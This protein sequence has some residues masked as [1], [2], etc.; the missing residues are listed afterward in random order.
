FHDTVLTRANV[1][2]ELA[3]QLAFVHHASYPQVPEAG[4]ELLRADDTTRLGIHVE[5][6]EFLWV[7]LLVQA[8]EGVGAEKLGE[9]LDAPNSRVSRVILKYLLDAVGKRGVEDLHAFPKLLVGLREL[10]DARMRQ[11]ERIAAG[12][13]G[14][15][16]EV[17]VPVPVQIGAVVLLE[18]DA[19]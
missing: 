6:N 19:A 1:L 2:G 10:L 18:G 9:D 16:T 17:A 15:P 11:V 12:A 14:V 5:E 8:R 3:G 13:E 7:V 4:H